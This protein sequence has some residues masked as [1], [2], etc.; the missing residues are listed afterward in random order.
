MDCDDNVDEVV[1][2]KVILQQYPAACPNGTD[3][4]LHKPDGAER[5]VLE[6]GLS[7]FE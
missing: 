7:R 6:V 3:V 1:Q 5:F 2:F 4:N